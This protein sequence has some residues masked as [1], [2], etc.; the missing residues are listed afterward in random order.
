MGLSPF[1]TP[2]KAA[3]AH[4]TRVKQAMAF[5]RA[6]LMSGPRP[7]SEMEVLAEASGF[8]ST[9]LYKARRRAGVS[10]KRLGKQWI[11]Q[12]AA[13]RKAAKRARVPV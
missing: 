5:L 11:W 9:T 8:T 10:S 6:H 13:Q 4:E 1:E 12:L 2:A 3:I 7:A